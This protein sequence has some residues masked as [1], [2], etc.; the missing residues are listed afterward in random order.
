MPHPYI[1]LKVESFVFASSHALF[2]EPG[3][4]HAFLPGT[5]L[6]LCGSP[7]PGYARKE[8]CSGPRDN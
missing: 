5:A 1:A 7:S 8:L 3:R 6:P 4:I 2:Q